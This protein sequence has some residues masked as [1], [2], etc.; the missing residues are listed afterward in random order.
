LKDDILEI[1]IYAP[2]DN[3][4]ENEKMY[5]KFDIPGILIKFEEETKNTSRIDTFNINN[6]FFV[7]GSNGTIAEMIEFEINNIYS[8]GFLR[9]KIHYK[10]YGITAHYINN[11]VFSYYQTACLHKYLTYKYSWWF[12]GTKIIEKGYL[13]LSDLKYQKQNKEDF[14][15]HKSY[16]KRSIKDQLELGP[17]KPISKWILDN[18]ISVNLGDSLIVLGYEDPYSKRYYIVLTD[19]LIQVTENKPDSLII[20]MRNDPKIDQ[21]MKYW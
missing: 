4:C 11:S 13:G 1:E 9:G 5:V 7:G 14:L 16:F 8:E 2:E 10:P 18:N 15:Y 21:N 19:T 6:S 12:K 3:K 17:K 20:K